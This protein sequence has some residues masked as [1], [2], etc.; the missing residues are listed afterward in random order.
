MVTLLVNTLF[1]KTE[2]SHRNMLCMLTCN[3]FIIAILNELI[4]RLKN[5]QFYFLLELNIDSCNAHKQKYFE[6]LN[7]KNCW[8]TTAYRLRQPAA[9]LPLCGK[10]LFEK[11]AKRNCKNMREPQFRYI[12]IFGTNS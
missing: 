5:S 10:N 4:I 9:L 2:F 8:R 1:W 6:V 12:Q 11:E 3:R 7:S